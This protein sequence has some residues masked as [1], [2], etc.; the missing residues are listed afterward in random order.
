[1]GSF[2]FNILPATG[3]Q[4]LQAEKMSNFIIYPAYPNPF[5]PITHIRFYLPITTQLKVTIYNALGEKITTLHTG[6]MNPGLHQLQ[7]NARNLGS[8]IYFYEISTPG[9]RKINKIMLLK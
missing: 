3:I 1:M 4:S 8:G 6:K 5:N 2:S 9:F 7:W